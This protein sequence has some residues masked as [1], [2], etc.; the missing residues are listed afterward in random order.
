MLLA[1]PTFSRYA[2]KG[3]ADR[4]AGSE[5]ILVL[6]LERPDQVDELAGVAASGRGA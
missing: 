2:A 4:T 6:G 5:V 1:E 3:I